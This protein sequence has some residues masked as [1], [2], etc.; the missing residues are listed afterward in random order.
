[1]KPLRI[2]TLALFALFARFVSVP[3]P[4]SAEDLVLS[5]AQMSVW[6]PDHWNMQRAG[7]QVTVVE[8]NDQVALTFVTFDPNQLN[9]MLGRMDQAIAAFATNVQLVSGP[10]QRM[11]NGLPITFIDAYGTLQGIP[12]DISVAVM[13]TPN[14]YGLLV[15]GLVQQAYLP[16]HESTLSGMFGS[17]RPMVAAVYPVQPVVVQWGTAY[18]PP[19]PRVVVRPAP[20]VVVQQPVQVIVRPAQPVMVQPVQTVVVQPAQ[21]VFQGS[22]RVNAPPPQPRPVIQGSGSVRVH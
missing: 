8:P 3:S 14:G 16:Y 4:V 1:M 10:E 19:P 6:V 9:A 20:P 21:P 22:V 17:L 15:V 18:A 7:N 5:Q 13:R 11:L 2:L 12:V